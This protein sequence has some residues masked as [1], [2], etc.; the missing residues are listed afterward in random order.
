[1][2]TDPGSPGSFFGKSAALTYTGYSVEPLNC[3]CVEAETHVHTVHYIDESCPCV[4]RLHSFAGR[5]CANAGP[6]FH[7]I[8]D[9]DT[10]S[11]C[12]A[13]GNARSDGDTRAYGKSS[14][15]RAAFVN[16]DCGSYGDTRSDHGPHGQSDGYADSYADAHADT[17]SDGQ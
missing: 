7:G 5:C 16:T 17:G 8:T 6:G 12:V 4:E 13:Y 1:M 9:S 14:A 3:H 2:T 15:H 10:C 11:Y